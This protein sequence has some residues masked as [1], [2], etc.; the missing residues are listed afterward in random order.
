MNIRDVYNNMKVF[1]FDTQDRLD[2]KLDKL[3]SIMNK[4]TVQGSNQIKPFKPKM[5]QG[6]RRGQTRN[7]Y[8]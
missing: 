1:T 3:K 7:Y 6:K 8:D 2:D 5:Y 4:M